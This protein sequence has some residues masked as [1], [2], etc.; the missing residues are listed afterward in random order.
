LR[1][2]KR[3]VLDWGVRYFLTAAALLA[4]LSALAVFLSW[5]GRPLT[6]LLGQWENVYGLLALLGVVTLAILGMLYKIVPFLVW[7]AT[8][9]PHIGAQKVPALSDLYSS[10]LQV[11]GYWTYLAGLAT[12]C[13]MTVRADAPGLRWGCLLLVL[14]LAIF[15]VN[16]AKI[17][18]HLVTPR[19]EP[20]LMNAKLEARA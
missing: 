1:G 18:R 11:L 7:Y 9:S 8:Y 17:L 19:L 4:P 16:L 13:V 15:G 3:R 10:R 14:S 6:P 12:V 5:P 20:L 2:R